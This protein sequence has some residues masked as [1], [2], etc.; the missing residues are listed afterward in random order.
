MIADYESLLTLDH[1]TLFNWTLSDVPPK[2]GAVIKEWVSAISAPSTQAGKSKQ[3]P[4][5]SSSHSKYNA[6][7]VVPSLIGG[8]TSRSSATSVLTDSIKIISHT[9]PPDQSKVKVEIDVISLSDEGGLSDNDEMV[10]KEREVA[11]NSPPKGKKRITSE[12]TS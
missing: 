10:G 7:S 12:V 1:F 3:G 6:G 4:K 9:A 11:I 5:S 2:R 8:S